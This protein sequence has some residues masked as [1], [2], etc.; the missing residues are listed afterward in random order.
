MPLEEKRLYYECSNDYV[1]LDQVQPW[2]DYVKDNHR[3]FTREGTVLL[4]LFCT[5]KTLLHIKNIS[6]PLKSQLFI[7]PPPPLLLRHLALPIKIPSLYLEALLFLLIKTPS[8]S[9]ST[10]ALSLLTPAHL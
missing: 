6:P 1:T 10:S 3:F 5:I 8:L 2:P 9:L 4:M 7:K